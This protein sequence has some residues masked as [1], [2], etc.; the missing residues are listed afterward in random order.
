MGGFL[1]RFPKTGDINVVRDSEGH[2]LDLC[3]QVTSRFLSYV[4]IIEFFLSSS[5][6]S[7]KCFL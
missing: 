4:L 1:R 3:E 6:V 5:F 2:F 7:P